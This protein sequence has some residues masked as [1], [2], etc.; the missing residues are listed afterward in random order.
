MLYR[1]DV[2]YAV[3]GV[4]VALASTMGKNIVLIG[5]GTPG[6]I[7]RMLGDRLSD[8]GHAVYTLSHMDHGMPRS[9]VADFGDADDA[10]SKF[11]ALTADLDRIDVLFFNSNPRAQVN[12]EG[13]WKSTGW[14]DK[15][16][17]LA[18]FTGHVVIPHMISLAA[19]SKM[20]ADSVILF[21]STGMSMEVPRDGWTDLAGYASA[22]AAQNHLMLALARHNDRDAKAAA[23]FPIIDYGDPDRLSSVFDRIHH[24]V[25]SFDPAL[26]GTIVKVYC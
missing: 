4:D 11:R 26:S 18:M 10:L 21:M 19:L 9:A 22:K 6:R 16:L 2:Q 13:C 24:L 7:G 20:D 1:I 5:G 17:W 15:D 3:G 12:G 14:V 23:V 8:E 25:T